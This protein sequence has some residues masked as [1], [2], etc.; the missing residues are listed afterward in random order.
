MIVLKMQLVDKNNLLLRFDRRPPQVPLELLVGSNGSNINEHFK[1][2][3]FYNITYQEVLK[4]FD[5][6]SVDLL[7]IVRNYSHNLRN[8]FSL[9]VPWH[10]S[11]PSTNDTFRRIFDR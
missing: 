1:L 9:F 8:S 3:V 6:E 11:A 7:R 2:Y 5:N 4:V 10:S